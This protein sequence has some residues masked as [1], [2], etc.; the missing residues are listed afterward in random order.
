MLG[1]LVAENLVS[2]TR[3]ALHPRKCVRARR[4]KG[5]KSGWIPAPAVDGMT[6]EEGAERPRGL[7]EAGGAET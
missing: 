6:R 7:K 3:C 2:G 4:G 1:G 5:R